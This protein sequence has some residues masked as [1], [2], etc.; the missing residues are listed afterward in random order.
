[1]VLVWSAVATYGGVPGDNKND[2]AKPCIFYPID[3]LI[4]KLHY[5][6]RIVKLNQPLAPLNVVLVCTILI[7]AIS[8]CTLH[9]QSLIN[10]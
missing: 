3:K 9:T 10:I 8:F 5:D 1:M 7:L 6:L 4:Y 2:K